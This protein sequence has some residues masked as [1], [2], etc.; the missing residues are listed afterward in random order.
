VAGQGLL[1]RS[2]LERYR[3]LIPGDKDCQDEWEAAIA[4]PKK[5]VS[6]LVGQMDDEEQRADRD[7]ENY[8][9]CSEWEQ[10]TQNYFLLYHEVKAHL[11]WV[12]LRPDEAE[13]YK[14]FQVGDCM[15]L[16]PYVKNLSLIHLMFRFGTVG[17]RRRAKPRVIRWGLRG[18]RGR[19]V[20]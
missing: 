15:C 2:E 3:K 18:G 20:V 7:K 13:A 12:A 8:H 19:G 17:R 10:T 6:L 9:D 14:R 11:R 5:Y 16:F 4:D 1:T